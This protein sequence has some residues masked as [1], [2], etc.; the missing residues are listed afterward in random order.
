MSWSQFIHAARMWAHVDWVLFISALLIALA[1]LITMHSF[2]AE[3]TFF[4]NQ[5]VWLVVACAVFL[6]ASRI[7]YRFL[8]EGVPVI[9]LFV[10][11]AILLVLIF[12]FGEVSK[13]AQSRFNFGAFAAQ[14]AELA[15]VVLIIVLS[16]YFAHL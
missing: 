8:R 13:G 4:D 11:T 14:P 6:I 10:F 9:L 15:K 12:I 3:N 2:S 1:G 16:K 7:D 5:I